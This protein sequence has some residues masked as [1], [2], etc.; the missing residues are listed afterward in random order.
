MPTL[1][2]VHIMG[3]LGKSPELR[4]T[5]TGIPVT[6]LNVATTY[7]SKNKDGTVDEDTEWHR[8]IVWNKQAELCATYLHK[9]RPVYVEGRLHTRTWDDRTGERKNLTEI[10]ASNVL[11]LNSLKVQHGEEGA[12][13]ADPGSLEPK[14][15]RL[16]RFGKE[17]KRAAR[18]QSASPRQNGLGMASDQEAKMASQYKDI[19][20]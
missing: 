19:P 7:T 2:R 11:F 10:I 16:R 9:G 14:L 1:N 5:P 13:Q 12:K 20:F 6:T 8:V 17:K 3:Y 4:F 15:E 18:I